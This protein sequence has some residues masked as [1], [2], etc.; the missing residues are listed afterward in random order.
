MDDEQFKEYEKRLI[1]VYGKEKAA[2]IIEL[3]SV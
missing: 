1:A 3:T 2:E